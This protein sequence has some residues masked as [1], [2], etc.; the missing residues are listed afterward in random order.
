MAVFLLVTWTIL[1]AFITFVVG[2]WGAIAWYGS[3]WV[4]LYLMLIGAAMG[5]G[6]CLYLR[7][8][9]ARKYP[10]R[11]STDAEVV[12]E[13]EEEVSPRVTPKPRVM[14]RKQPQVSGNTPPV[15]PSVRPGSVV[16]NRVRSDPR[17]T[18]AQQAKSSAATAVTGSGKERG[19]M[20]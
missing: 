5:T 11:Y 9:Y 20:P 15:R 17:A 8:E 19:A 4:G 2:M 6:I 1:A 16:N 12:I 10:T 18:V 13:Y 7:E 14:P 3:I